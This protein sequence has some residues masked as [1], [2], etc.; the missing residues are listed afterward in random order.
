[1]GGDSPLALHPLMALL[2]EAQWTTAWVTQ[3]VASRCCLDEVLEGMEVMEGLTSALRPLMASSRDM[4]DDYMGRP[5]AACLDGGLQGDG[6]MLVPTISP[7]RLHGHQPAV[8]CWAVLDDQP[9]A[10]IMS[11]IK[12]V[13]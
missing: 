6:V 3:R 8:P 4:R 13:R 2:N 1:M 7:I 5:M 12:L 10:L 11:T 9:P